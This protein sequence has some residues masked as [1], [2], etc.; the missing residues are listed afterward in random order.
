MLMRFLFLLLTSILFLRC[1]KKAE[2]ENMME[3]S[4]VV[5][6]APTMNGNEFL[7]LSATTVNSVKEYGFVYNYDGSGPL[8]NTNSKQISFAGSQLPASGKFEALLDGSVPDVEYAIRAY[9]LFPDDRI[10]YSKTYRYKSPARGTWKKL[11]GFPGEA[12]SYAVSFASQNKGYVGLGSGISS[13]SLKDFWEFDPG[14]AQWTKL[15]DFPGEAR[16]GAFQ[17]SIGDKVY[18]GGGA[19]YYPATQYV[20]DAYND[21]YEFTP[22]TKSWRKLADFPKF[23]SDGWGIFGSYSFSIGNFGFV[24]GG[25]DLYNAFYGIMK[26]DP[27]TDVWTIETS[28]PKDHTGLLYAIVFGASFVRNDTLYVGTGIP[29]FR[30]GETT[31]R[32]FSYD[33]N[34]KKWNIEWFPGLR[35]AYA[36]GITN[37]N[38]GLVGFGYQTQEIW[39]FTGNGRWKMVS[40]CPDSYLN[41][42]GIAFT[43]GNKTYVGLGTP[44]LDFLS[45]NAIYEYTHTR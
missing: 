19:K 40:R 5:M 9:A 44:G 21:F 1:E 25:R 34:Q 11:N 37:S 14:T 30:R 31:E 36:F 3:S 35:R 38:T 45:P 7:Q 12:R 43:I 24:G 4:L 17:F 18:V 13:G 6:D 33:L 22:A 26:Y 27:S 23:T 29:D 20:Y 8:I 15:P 16:S 39:Q 41:K 10:F 32:F 28:H 2:L 42:G